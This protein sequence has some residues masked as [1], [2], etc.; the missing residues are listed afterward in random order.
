[1]EEFFYSPTEDATR[2]NNLAHGEIIET[3]EIPA[4]AEGT[5]AVYRKLKEK[6]SF[7]WPIVETCVL[8]TMSGGS[9]RDAR[10]VFGSVAPTPRRSPQAEALLKG[11]RP[12]DDLARRAAE[13]AVAGAKPLEHNGYKVRLARVE[14][15]RA[16][17]QAWA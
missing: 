8:L 4:P 3:I 1:M 16:I 6:E 10:V 2:E 13:A 11:A 5:R 15:E 17:K 9:V 12:S 14:L 7:D